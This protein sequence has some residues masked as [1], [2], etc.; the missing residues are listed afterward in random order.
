MFKILDTCKGGRRLAHGQ[1]CCQNSLRAD[2]VGPLQ[3]LLRAV[4]G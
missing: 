2:Q 4:A 1:R 3:E